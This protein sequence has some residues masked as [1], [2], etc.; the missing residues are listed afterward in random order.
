MENG[1]LLS[2]SRRYRNAVSTLR[3]SDASGCGEMA[4]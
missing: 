3:C 2:G 1:E 4:S